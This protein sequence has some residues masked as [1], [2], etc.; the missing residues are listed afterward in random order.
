MEQKNQQKPNAGTNWDKQRKQ[1]FNP[2]PRNGPFF[3]PFHLP[4]LKNQGTTNTCLTIKKSMK[5]TL[6]QCLGRHALFGVVFLPNS[7][8]VDVYMDVYTVHA[9]RKR[10]YNDK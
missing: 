10:I 9:Y 2:P 8:M 6:T 3:C 7:R 4:R 1:Y 5:K